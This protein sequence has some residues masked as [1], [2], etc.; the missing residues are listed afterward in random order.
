MVKI[1]PKNDYELL[2]Q[3]ET[4]RPHPLSVLKT[5]LLLN[6]RDDLERSSCILSI[7]H[8]IA[9]SWVTNDQF[10]SNSC[11]SCPIVWREAHHHDV[12]P[13]G[14]HVGGDQ[15]PR[16]GLAEGLDDHVALVVWHFRLCGGG[17]AGWSPAANGQ[18]MPAAGDPSERG[19]AL[20]EQISADGRI[21]M[22]SV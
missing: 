17:G 13:T 12:Q 6:H 3:D 22:T 10:I 18:R 16:H 9:I 19:S 4:W 5:A 8:H 2:T 1:S 20:S 7:V 21:G 15:H 14:N 11:H